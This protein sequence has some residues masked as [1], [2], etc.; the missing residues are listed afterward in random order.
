MEVH[1]FVRVHLA[2]L[3]QQASQSYMRIMQHKVEPI[4]LPQNNE[5]G[6]ITVSPGECGFITVSAKFARSPDRLHNR[7]GLSGNQRSLA[8]SALSKMHL[9]QY[10]RNDAT[11]VI[12]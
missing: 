5:C 2:C 8:K 11:D 10:I 12:E 4:R 9:L 6:F 3:V 7:E 1:E